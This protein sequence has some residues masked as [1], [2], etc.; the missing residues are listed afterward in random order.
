MERVEVA[1]LEVEVG[2]GVPVADAALGVAFSVSGELVVKLLS[3]EL[4]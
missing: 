1:G 3:V 2:S 4:V